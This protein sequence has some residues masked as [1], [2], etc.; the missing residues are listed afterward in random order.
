MSFQLEQ[1]LTVLCP[2]E[3]ERQ[4]RDMSTDHRTDKME[5]SEDSKRGIN[6]A[7]WMLL[8][9]PFHLELFSRGNERESKV[10]VVPLQRFQGISPHM[11]IQRHRYTFPVPCLAHFTSSGMSCRIVVSAFPIKMVNKPLL[12]KQCVDIARRTHFCLN[13]KTSE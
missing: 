2:G 5:I 3:G 10:L 9:Q 11:Q 12:A 7:L 1:S 4:R 6:F 8:S 13:S